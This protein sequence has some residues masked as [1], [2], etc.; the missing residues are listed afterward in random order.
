MRR[1]QALLCSG[2]LLWLVGCGH[3]NA[4]RREE[5]G[6]E[7]ADSDGV[8]VKGS[9]AQVRILALI[10]R[11]QFAEAQALITEAGAAGLITRE[12][13][14]R[15]TERIALLN[16]RLG[17]LPA[18]IQRVHDFPSRLKDSTLFEIQQMLSRKDFSLATQSQLRMA[19]KLIKEESRFMETY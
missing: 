2:L 11:G 6:W 18:R 7:D 12:Q 10:G 3:A 16:T 19:A 9:S 13:V 14:T 17:D 15:L 1:W 4:S 8:R 5:S